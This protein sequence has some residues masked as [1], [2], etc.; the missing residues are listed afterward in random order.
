MA[1]SFTFNLPRLR[2]SGPTCQ[3]V[4]K[5]SDPI[6]EK[7]ESEKKKVP[8]VSVLALIDTGASTTAVSHRVVKKLKLVPRGTVQVYTSHKKPETR[9]EFDIS[10]AFDARTRLTIVKVLDASLQSH[11]IDCLIGRDVLD[12]GVLT[13]NGP[14]KQVILK[15]SG[16]Q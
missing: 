7:L 14:K 4:I 5:P 16:N 11:D 13:Y 15:F 8:R 1:R 9:N 6:I 2:E 12:H 3:V 10:L